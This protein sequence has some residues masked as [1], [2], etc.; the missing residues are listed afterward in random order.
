MDWFQFYQM[1]LRYCHLYGALP[2]HKIRILIQ[3]IEEQISI[4]F[5]DE[6]TRKHVRSQFDHSLFFYEKET[7]NHYSSAQKRMTDFHHKLMTNDT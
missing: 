4:L 3:D 1:K 5:A 6:A 7:L 2:P